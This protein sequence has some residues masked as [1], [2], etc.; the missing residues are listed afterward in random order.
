MKLDRVGKLNVHLYPNAIVS[1]SRLLKLSSSLQETGLFSETHLV[2]MARADLPAVEP[3]GDSRSIR[4]LGIA[5]T[6]KESTMRKAWR[7]LHW[8]RSVLHTYWREPISCV[9]AHNVWVLPIAWML[10]VRARAVL[11]YNAHELETES[12][13]MTGLRRRLAQSFE[14]LFLRRARIMSVVNES[15][16]KWYRQHRAGPHPIAVRN[17]PGPSFSETTLRTEIGLDSEAILYVHTGHLIEGRNIHGI[18][19]VFSTQ[20]DKHVAFLGDGPLG[21]EVREASATFP[22]LHLVSPVPSSQ[23]VATI[24]DA[25]VALVLIEPKCLSYQLASPNKLFEAL[26]A[27]VP[28]ICSDLPVA[29]AVLGDLAGAWVLDSVS[30]LGQAVRRIG[31]A[32]ITEFRNSWRGLPTWEDEVAPLL[33]AYHR[34]LTSE[35]V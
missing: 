13:T 3:V 30:D 17:V 9:N 22:N 1:E 24:R 28:A 23:V 10:S 25:D 16:A 29:R 15:Y 5:P 33:A 4:R 27:G 7:M 34:E 14:W 32:E 31:R 19:E 20:P 18:L 11:V 6:P 2:G 8:Y 21:D 26:A 35:L 12:L